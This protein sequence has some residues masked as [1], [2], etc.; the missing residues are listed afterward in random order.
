[1]WGEFRAVIENIVEPEE[2]RSDRAA[3]PELAHPL[4]AYVITSRRQ[5]YFGCRF[6]GL[7][8]NFICYLVTGKK[9]TF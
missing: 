3:M 6:Y 2:L 5:F 1:M 8:T 9:C 4:P 7:K